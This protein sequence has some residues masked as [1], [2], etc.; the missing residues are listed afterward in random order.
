MYKIV[1][2]RNSKWE[3]FQYSL[4]TWFDQQKA[5]KQAEIWKCHFPNNSYF[6]TRV[7]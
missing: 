6:V 3:D 7:G 4:S 5:E 1:W 2:R